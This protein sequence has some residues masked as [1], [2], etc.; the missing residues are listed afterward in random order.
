MI[1]RR[2]PDYIFN[3]IKTYIFIFICFFA[4]SF[5]SLIAIPIFLGWVGLEVDINLVYI[6]IAYV[7]FVIILL[8]Y[9]LRV[10]LK[11]YNPAEKH[12]RTILISDEEEDKYT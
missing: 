11:K 4:Y 6:I 3:E 8:G 10:F 1:R 2:D 12:T 5:V 7:L 9:Y